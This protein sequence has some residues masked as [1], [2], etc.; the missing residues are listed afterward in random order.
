MN[1]PIVFRQIFRVEKSTILRKPIPPDLPKPREGIIQLVR[2]AG[3]LVSR[4]SEGDKLWLHVDEFVEV[5]MSDMRAEIQTNA[6][7]RD[8]AYTF[9]MTAR[10]LLKVFDPTIAASTGVDDIGP[11]VR[12][13]I[14]M[15]LRDVGRA[16]EIDHVE[17]CEAAASQA[18]IPLREAA[19][20]LARYG[21]VAAMT[22]AI[23]TI[24]AKAQKH[25][26]Q[27]RDAERELERMTL[28]AQRGITEREHQIRAEE[29]RRFIER[30]REDDVARALRNGPEGEL[31]YRIAKDPDNADAIMAKWA[32]ERRED[33]GKLIDLFVSLVDSG[34]VDDVVLNKPTAAIADQIVAQLGGGSVKP[35]QRPAELDRGE[36]RRPRD[37]DR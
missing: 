33:S 12:A 31:A 29:Q 34:K 9:D 13:V 28:E 5:D 35:P 4:P 27:R 20:P 19:G 18:L 21:V 6:P 23:V 37:S 1:Y 11:H 17:H 24:D 8:D 2:L 3:Q 16:H 7:S 14:D 25:L 22:Q 10:L 15:C 30:A 36:P 26:Q 32:A